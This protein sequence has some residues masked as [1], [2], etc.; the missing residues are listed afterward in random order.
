MTSPAPEPPPATRP[1]AGGQRLARLA[2]LGLL[3]SVGAQRLFALLELAGVS[4]RIPML[5]RVGLTI[6]QVQPLEP[7]EILVGVALLV[8]TLPRGA[9][10]GAGLRFG[11][12]M[13]A[14]LGAWSLLAGLLAIYQGIRLGLVQTQF[15]GRANEFAS[16]AFTF[17]LAT[18][19]FVPA[20]LATLVS[21]KTL[22]GARGSSADPS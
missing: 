22:R 14:A 15:Q 8:L 16:T 12:W 20:G 21:L 9:P 18:Q 7:L 19:T 11:L 4:A 5:D 13:G 10:H 3:L 17:R 2:G 6:F 1:G